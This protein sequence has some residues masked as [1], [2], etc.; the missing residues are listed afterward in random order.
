MLWKCR[1]HSGS[2]LL[3]DFSTNSDKFH[4]NLRLLLFVLS[5]DG[6]SACPTVAVCDGVSVR[7][8]ASAAGLSVCV[9]VWTIEKPTK[10]GRRKRRAR[11]AAER[12][13]EAKPCLLFISAERYTRDSPNLYFQS[14]SSEFPS[15]LRWITFT[16]DFR[17]GRCI[18]IGQ[19][20][21]A[22]QAGRTAICRIFS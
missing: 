10:S 2:A 3:S 22:L 15:G 13:E 16:N 11:P 18:S 21:M 1:D 8:V 20:P 12:R 14:T 6:L 17:L 7:G 4:V 5:S 19:K 9:D